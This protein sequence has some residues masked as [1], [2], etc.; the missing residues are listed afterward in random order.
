ETVE[1]TEGAAG[2]PQRAEPASPQDSYWDALANWSW[3]DSE[4]GGGK[5]RSGESR[6]GGG[7]APR[8]G[9]RG[10]D[11]RRER[12]GSDRPERQVSGPP[13]AAS[14]PPRAPRAPAAEASDDFGLGVTSPEPGFSPPA[15]AARLEE[16]PAH[17]AHDKPE[18][19]PAGIQQVKP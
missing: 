3:D 17:A 14:P 9:S 13:A 1:P 7:P 10:R 11:D 19:P 5:A 16:R 12:R 15:E 2:E 18:P 8:A 6:S 4:G